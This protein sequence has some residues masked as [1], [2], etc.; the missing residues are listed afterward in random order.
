MCGV[1]T[2]PSYWRV[3]VFGKDGSAEAIGPTALTVRR[4]D[5][6]PEHFTFE[7][8]SSLRAELEDLKF[9]EKVKAIL[10]KLG[11]KV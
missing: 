8:L 10:A 2:T 9:E 4:T 6:Q 3:H 1:R 5:A 11:V 7:P